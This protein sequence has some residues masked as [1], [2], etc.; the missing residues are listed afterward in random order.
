[1]DGKREAFELDGGDARRDYIDVRDAVDAY[2]R[3]LS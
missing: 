3:L 2:W 1:M